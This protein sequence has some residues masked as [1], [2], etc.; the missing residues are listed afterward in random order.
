[1]NIME[2]SAVRAEF[3]AACPLCDGQGMRVV[4][5]PMGRRSALPCSC[6]V[7]QRARRVLSRARIP[8]RYEHCTLESF[9]YAYNGA[10]PSLW[11][12]YKVAQK[13]A[14]QYPVFDTEGTG[15]LLVGSAGLGKTHLAVAV[16]QN[17]IM[18]RGATGLFYEYGDLLRSVQSTYSAGVSANEL[19]IL[20][21][22]FETEVLVLDELGSMR[23]SE[24]ASDT[25]AYLLNTRYNANR[26]SIITTNYPN[27]P[28]LGMQ[29][30]Q[31]SEAQRD[32]QRAV[33]QETLGDRI[34]ERLWSR[35][36][37]MCIEVEMSGADFR[38]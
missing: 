38:Q 21:P 17:L 29:S 9:E 24:W 30:G 23:P 6:R 35:L 1:M 27:R 16:L 33:R 34:T 8:K 14:Q 36:I 32:A 31:V 18:E 20:R 12:A 7:Q 37:E 22:V 11:K 26:T 15:L 25:V 13:F 10:N 4:E 2:H 3:D 5:D 28:P 19:D